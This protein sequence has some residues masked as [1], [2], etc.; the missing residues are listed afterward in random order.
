[1]QKL[2]RTRSGP[3]L[4]PQAVTLYDIADAMDPTM[5]G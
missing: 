3:F 5:R 4:E 2:R 1:M